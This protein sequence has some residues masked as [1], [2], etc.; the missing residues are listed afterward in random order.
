[1][2]RIIGLY[3]ARVGFCVGERAISAGVHTICYEHDIRIVRVLIRDCPKRCQRLVQCTIPPG[4]V[5]V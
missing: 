3:A 5:M 1:M 2:Y 4:I